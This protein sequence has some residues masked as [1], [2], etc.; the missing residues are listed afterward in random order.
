M[1]LDAAGLH[2]K[3]DQCRRPLPAITAKAEEIQ[4]A[5][6]NVA[7]NALQA[8]EGGGRLEI[9]SRR[10][11]DFVSVAIRD[12]GHGIEAKDLARI[13]DPFFTTKEPDQGEGLG[14]FVV[15]RIV[16]KYAGTLA[17]ESEPGQGTLCTIEFP[18]RAETGGES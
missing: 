6:F 9:D 18:M 11:G 13:R 16:E 8:M 2:P 14:L 10:R 7:H 4:Q 15:Q 12:G 5:I 17:F 1:Y 3:P